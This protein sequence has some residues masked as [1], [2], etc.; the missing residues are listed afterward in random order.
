VGTYA[1]PTAI[2]PS[3]DGRV[4]VVLGTYAG[5]VR[6]VDTRTRTATGPIKVGA[7]PVAAAVV[8]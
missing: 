2:V 8:R 1:Y 5:T 3:S 7:L 4:D 6:L